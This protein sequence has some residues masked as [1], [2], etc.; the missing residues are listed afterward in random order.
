MGGIPPSAVRG[1]CA[2]V[3]CAYVYA[4]AW[5]CGCARGG[6]DGGAVRTA[7]KSIISGARF[8]I[9]EKRES[10]SSSSSLCLRSA[11]WQRKVRV[12]AE[13]KSQSLHTPR[14]V[15]STFSSFRS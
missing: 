7:C 5:A 3:S 12:S 2:R 8:I 6:I 10:R 13:P 9:V 1:A 14:C 11:S 15:S 4:C